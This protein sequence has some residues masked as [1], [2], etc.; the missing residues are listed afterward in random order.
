M[1]TIDKLVIDTMRTLAIDAV[2]AAGTGH[3][4]TAMGA[5]DVVYT[6][7][8]KHLLHN[9][10]NPKWLNRD[11]FVLS[12]G[13]ASLLLYSMLYLTGY[14][15]LTLEEI[16]CYRRYGSLTPGHPENFLTP[17]V[18]VTTGPLGQGFANAVGIAIAETHLGAYFNRP[19][20]KIINHFTYAFVGDGDLM[21]GVCAEAASIAGHLRLGKLITFYDDNRVT[22]E[23]NTSIA[24]T[25]NSAKRFEAYNW[26][27][28]KV[29]GYD[30][31]AVSAAIDASKADPRPSIIIC[32]THVAYGSPNKQ[33]TSGAHGAP[34]GEEEVRLTKQN[35]GWPLEPAFLVPEEV[36]EHTRKAIEKGQQLEAVWQ[37]TYDDYAQNFPDLSGELQA[38]FGGKL[39]EGWHTNLPA[40][41]PKDGKIAARTTSGKMVNYVA[42]KIPMFFGGAADVGPSIE[43]NMNKFADYSADNY[44]GRN[45]HFGVREHAMGGILNGLALYG[46]VIPYGGTYLVFS[47]YMRPSIRMAALMKLPVVYVFSHD[48]VL[49]GTDGPTH[50]P[51]EHLL[52]FRATPNL[53]VL[54]PCDA[55]ETVAAWR[56]ALE[57]HT[58]PTVLSLFRHPLPVLTEEHSITYQNVSKGAYILSESD[59]EH[60]DMLLMGTGSEV[61]LLIEAQ[62]IL[63][64]EG[65]STRVISCPSLEIFDQQSQEYQ[66]LVLPKSVKCRLAVEAGNTLGWWKYVGSSGSVF[67]VDCFGIPGSTQDVIEAFNFTGEGVAIQAR[68]LYSAQ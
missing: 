13:H 45:V 16:K 20:Y 22:I 24:F 68:K 46:G 57:N 62:N 67:G 58:G 5:A 37:L 31:Q 44:A 35:L 27:V 25:E 49:V 18:E 36:L 64:A 53:T 50:Q 11:R 66:V 55:N 3:P 41:S 39:P 61:H 12:A 30:I 40:F 1:D 47:D 29:D 15:R 33:N 51:V 59:K 4:G 56:M 26:H 52:M 63:S 8:S 43:T 65:I 21:E 19:D 23:G 54:R 14:E 10:S 42:D 34:L 38:A 48:S 32:R 7:W 9:P 6:L 60:P 17:G 2:Q 28:E